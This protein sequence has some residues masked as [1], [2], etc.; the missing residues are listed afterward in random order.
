MKKGKDIA[1]YVFLTISSIFSV[2]P[3]YYMLCGATNKSVDVIS[4][5]LVPGFY[6]KENF[7][8]L[9][10]NQNLSLALWNSFRNAVVLTV[11]SLLI[12]SV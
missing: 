10:S 7:K 3:L 5:K 8:S 11:I 2:F 9:I 4:G 1:V 12:W 6:L